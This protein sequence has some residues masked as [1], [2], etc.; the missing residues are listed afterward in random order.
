MILRARAI[1]SSR[2]MKPQ[3]AA[4]R[5][6]LR[7]ETTVAEVEVAVAATVDAVGRLRR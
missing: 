2:G 7:L 6:S 5:F 3:R 4:V 1:T